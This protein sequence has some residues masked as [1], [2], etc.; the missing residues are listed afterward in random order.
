[1]SLAIPP[2]DHYH[3][4]TVQ[5]RWNLFLRCGDIDRVKSG[6]WKRCAWHN[7]NVMLDIIVEDR[8]GKR[9][10]R[11]PHLGINNIQGHATIFF[12]A[13]TSS[14]GRHMTQEVRT[15]CNGQPSHY[16]IAPVKAKKESQTSL[17]LSAWRVAAHC[18]KI[19]CQVPIA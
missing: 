9:R 4:G 11:R 10:G 7:D 12:S 2:S 16:V 18:S 8:R 1:V 17:I 6:S 5:W 14:E 13:Q 19:K 3:F 15:R